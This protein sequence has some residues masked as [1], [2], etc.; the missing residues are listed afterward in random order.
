MSQ[1]LKCLGRK[2]F[3]NKFAFLVQ[4]RIAKW[5]IWTRRWQFDW[6]VGFYLNPS[7]TDD[8]SL[9]TEGSQVDNSSVSTSGASSNQ[10]SVNR[11]SPTHKNVS[12]SREN[13]EETK[14]KRVKSLDAFRGLSITI[15]IFVN[16]GGGGYW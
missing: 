7:D 15:M 10:Q 11:E 3:K 8:G 12:T 2:R 1:T 13:K 16:Y 4:G 5:L 14:R 9:I 6:H